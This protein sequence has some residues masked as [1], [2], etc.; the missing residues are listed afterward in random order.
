MNY[1]E[2]ATGL[3]MVLNTDPQA[4]GMPELIRSIYQ[5][6]FARLIFSQDSAQ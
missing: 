5:V 3:K 2:T 6:Y 4:V 1:I